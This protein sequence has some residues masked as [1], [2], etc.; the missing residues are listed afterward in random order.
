LAESSYGVKKEKKWFCQPNYFCF[1]GP[2]KAISTKATFAKKIPFKK[3]GTPPTP[4]P[5]SPAF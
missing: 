3:M 4:P 2:T 1:R 5:L